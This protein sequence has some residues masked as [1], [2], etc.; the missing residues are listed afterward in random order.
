[1]TGALLLMT[2]VPAHKRE[3]NKF[4][5]LFNIR[6]E[7]QRPGSWTR[8]GFI[9][10]TPSLWLFFSTLI[11]TIIHT[12]LFETLATLWLF[13]RKLLPFLGTQVIINFS[14]R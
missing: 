12:S 14:S 6:F 7:A 4:K 2:L 1:M 10:F 3:T 5:F 13:K 9:A 11:E 8:L